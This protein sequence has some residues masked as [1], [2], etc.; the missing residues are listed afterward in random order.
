MS[1]IAS[2][3]RLNQPDGGIHRTPGEIG[4]WVFIFGDLLVFSLFFAV[5]LFYRR[6]D[7][8]LFNASQAQLNQVFG[9]INTVLLLSSSW[10][11]ATAVHSARSGV[12]KTP[13]VMFLMALG[14]GVV[15][16]INKVF[17]YA[18]KIQA[19]ITVNTNDFFM[20][21]FI[22]TGVH[23]FHVLIGIGVLAYLANYSW[24]RRGS[25]STSDLQNLESGGIFW[26]L[27]DL[28]WIILFALLYLVN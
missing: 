19:G 3:T 1:S 16:I 26:H 21:F 2:D 4:I 11:V 12:E 9:L 24:S 8:E 23:A 28:L 6:V 13:P 14:C 18:E 22:F 17:E 27:V 25:M 5:F 15:F 7:V 20:Y 10:L